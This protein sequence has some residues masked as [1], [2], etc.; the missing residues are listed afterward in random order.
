MACC[1]GEKHTVCL[2]D[3]G[4]VHT[5]GHVDYGQLGQGDSVWSNRGGIL[6]SQVT[7]F[8]IKDQFFPFPIIK[9]IS[10]GA[11]FTICLDYEGSLYSFGQNNHGQAGMGTIGFHYHFPQK[12]QNIP[13][14]KTVSCG[15]YHTLV[16]TEDDNLWSFGANENG[17]LCHGNTFNQSTPQQTPFSN[18]VRIS[19]GYHSLFQNDKDEIYELGIWSI[20]PQIEAIKLENNPPN[21][22]QFCSGYHHSLFLNSEGNVFSIGFNN[23][24]NLG[25]KQK[26]LNEILNIPP[27]QTISCV[28]H[29]SYMID[30]DGNLWCFGNNSHY[31]L[32]LGD[33]SNKIEPTKS[34]KE[35][36]SQIASGCCGN[37]FFVKNYDNQ[38]FGVGYN[39]V[40]QLGNGTTS[41]QTEYQEINSDYST[42]WGKSHIQNRAKSAR[43]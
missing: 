26:N 4:I 33:S 15:V 17:Q 34:E 7:R 10:C 21:I 41:N 6:P 39:D 13:P 32:G 36:I 43:K 20:V 14:V 19:A 16:I 22:I 37:H 29:S 38:I 28:G 5:F 3:E 27:I 2:S 11:F 1:V 35:G 23:Y 40:G 31:Q 8:Y 9:Q 24:G 42:I 18:I 12:I 25:E 30:L